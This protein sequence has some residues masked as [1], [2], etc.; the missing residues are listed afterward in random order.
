[1]VLDS[2]DYFAL[3]LTVMGGSQHVSTLS[4]WVKWPHDRIS[5]VCWSSVD[6]II[7]KL[8]DNFKL[9]VFCQTCVAAF[10][11]LR[12]SISKGKGHCLIAVRL[13]VFGDSSSLFLRLI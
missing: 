6:E 12:A 7:L 10:K 4:K 11:Q 2:I 13:I 5:D 9:K 8:F 3:F 1:M